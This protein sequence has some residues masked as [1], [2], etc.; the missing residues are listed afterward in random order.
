MLEREIIERIREI[1]A[2]EARR[3]AGDFLSKYNAG[4]K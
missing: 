4:R 3:R 2:E 1:E